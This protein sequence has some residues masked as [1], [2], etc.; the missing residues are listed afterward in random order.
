[1]GYKR[2]VS[3]SILAVVGYLLSPLSW[4]NDAFVNLP[5]ALVFAWGVSAVYK[6]AFTVSLVVGYWLTNVLGLV[7][8][9]KGA[10]Q[11]LSDQ[12]K[13]P[14]RRELLKDLVISLLYTGL[15]VALIKF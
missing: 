8:M 12:E 10:Q 11:L 13:K 6:P 9:H 15:I 1:M 14:P 7:L 3:G 4:W 5:L 2:K